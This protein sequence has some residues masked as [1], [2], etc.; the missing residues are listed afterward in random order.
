MKRVNKFC[1]LSGLLV[2]LL[3]F[4][5][6]LAQVDYSTATLRGTVTDPQGA[7]IVSATVTATNT[8]TGVSKSA[9]T[10][11]DGHYQIPGLPPG[12][13]QISVEAKGFAKEV[14]KGVE[15]NVGQSQTYDARM[16]VGTAGETVEVSAESVPVIQTDQTQQANTINQLQVTEL[17]NIAHNITE[18]VYTLPG[19]SNAEAPRAQTPGF[20]GF[21]TTGF[22]IGG[23][24]GRN[25]LSTIDGGENEYG[26]GQYRVTTIPQDTIQEY[27]VNRNAFAA[28]FGFTNGSA[29]NIVTKSGG[30][31]F[32]GDL[33]GYFQNH[34][35]SATNWFNGIEGLPAA[36]NQN[37]YTGFT[38]G[39]PIKQDKLFFFL[40]YEY[41]KLDNPD[42]SNA[43]LLNAPTVTGPSAAQTAYVAGLKAS[44]DPFLIGFANGITPGL[45]PLNN[46]A[47]NTILTRQNGIFINPF[48]LHNTLARFD[49]QPNNNNSLSLRLE[50]A[51][52]DAVQGNPDNSS[53]LTRDFS[54]L[55][56]WNHNFGPSV[57]NQVLV[58][59][60][61]RNVANSIPNSP[62]QGVN[63]SLGNL[64]IGNL[65]GT[66]TFGSP[67]LT[68]YLAHQKRYQFEDNLTWNRGSHS[69]KIGASMRLA[70]YTVTDRLWFNN[71]FDFR[72][73]V[74]P[75]IALAPAA[76]Q[77]HLVAFNL[78]HGLPATGPTNTNLSAPQ[79]FAFGI[80]A[81]VLGGFNNATWTGWGKYFGSYIQDSWKINSRLTMNG[82][83]RFDVDG[84]PSPLGNSFYASPRLGFA[85]VPFGDQKTV[86]RAG[87]GLYVAPVDVLIPSYGALLDGSGRYIN[88][89]LGILSNTDPRVAQLWQTGVALGILPFGSLTPAQFQQFSTV[90]NPITHAVVI[91]GYDPAASGATVGY[92]VDPNYK[93]PYTFQGSFSIARQLGKSYSL[94]LGYNM[95][96][97][98][99]LQMPLETGYAAIPAGGCSPALLAV[100][101]GCT[102]ATGGP[103]YA[104]TSPQLQHTTYSSIGSSRYNALTASFTRRYSHNL[105]FQVNYTWS[106]AID[107]VIDFASF[108]NWYRPSLLGTYMTT[109]V[110]DVPHILVANAVY[111]TPY[112]AGSGNFLRTALADIT[113]CPVETIRSG[114]P[115][116]L[117]T[118]GLVNKVNG[119]TL[120]NNFATPFGVSRDT[121]RGA[122]YA[123]TD[124]KLGK[125]FYIN[126]DRGVRFELQA[127]GTNV[128]NRTN[129][130]KVSDVF[131]VRGFPNATL[132][133]GQTLNLITGP[134][135]GLHGIKPTSKSQIQQ[136]LAFAG[137]DLPRLVQFGLKLVF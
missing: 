74:I 62:F 12:F 65:G 54:V 111:T 98:V 120:D 135:T 123:T 75:L 106:K 21:G 72:D 30:N 134:F 102:D 83:V 76:V 61:P 58:Q 85:W 113:L 47:L 27:Q 82:G 39:G 73:G 80:P 91:P 99:H 133:N 1:F 112:K 92:S 130:N 11:T 93:N 136:P 38:V 36:Y 50:Y 59:L 71:E 96:H 55:G 28:E 117:R 89:V 18:A 8:G 42:F 105:Q 122:V 40:A 15:L 14:A 23:S 24:N 88:E 44:A 57:L 94:E 19:V 52:N 53:L 119:Q 68:P 107:N 115:F 128:F 20:T 70:D 116:S 32:H 10:Q 48:R 22:S 46:P 127:I 64:N 137:A 4:L 37:V 60:V 17:P 129:F 66:S 69:L 118:P 114:L 77:G 81:D 43:G 25:N 95:Y 131:D 29:I 41:R 97:G 9:T 126:R 6:A 79:S 121:L 84:E 7:V 35:T 31:R 103:L 34:S 49:A 108:Q 104:P 78:G 67:S 16:K 101:P 45:T 26:T 132:A 124:F 51:H 109:S 33:Y 63:F 86:I 13:Y 56:T 3:A 90:L 125:S 100:F 110:F 87:A 2:A 5:P